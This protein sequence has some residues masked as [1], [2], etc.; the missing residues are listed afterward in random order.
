M[1]DAEVREIADSSAASETCV[2]PMAQA[3]GYKR[4]SQI[5]VSDVGHKDW[6]G[7]SFLALKP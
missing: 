5:L 2:A 6:L 4:T 7:C 1:R 3:S